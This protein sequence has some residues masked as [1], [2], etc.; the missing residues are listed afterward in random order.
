MEQPI[1]IFDSGLGGISLLIEAI[2]DLPSEDFIYYGDNKNVPYGT[3]SKEKIQALM[4]QFMDKVL[5]LNPKAIVLACNTATVSSAKY[6]RGKYDLPIIGIEPAIKPALTKG[7]N[8]DKRVLL[9]ATE[10]T[11]QSEKLMGLA[12][13]VDQDH[14]LDILPMQNLVDFA[15]RL[16]FTDLEVEE[17]VGLILSSY[18]LDQYQSIVLG[19]THFIW[20]KPL[21]QKILPNHI[22]LVDGN[23]G[24]VRQLKRKIAGKENPQKEGKIKLHFSKRV[25][26]SVEGFL[27][28]KIQK[29]FTWIEL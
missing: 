21:F 5:A 4:D 11:S 13:D 8:Q 2:K 9:L 12:R 7:D 28:E 16:Q 25:S 10:T 1:V 17:D 14:R 15:E 19:C 18:D 22:K 24:T 20:Y 6:L 26:P 29:P 27:Q 3:K 23:R